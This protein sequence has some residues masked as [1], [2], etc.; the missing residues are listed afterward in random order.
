[1][2]PTRKSAAKL[3]LVLALVLPGVFLW[4]LHA[5]A[6]DLGRRSP[7]MSYD[8]A[9]YALAARELAEH[10]RLATSFAL[11]LELTHRGPPWPLAVAQPGL[12]VAEAAI[13]GLAPRDDRA[14]RAAPGAP[15]RQTRDGLTL[16]IPL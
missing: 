1:M 2:S 14:G 7:V 10:G 8:T 9:Q 6:W 16:I 15:L 5:R 12:V 4:L 13:F 11:P 3:T